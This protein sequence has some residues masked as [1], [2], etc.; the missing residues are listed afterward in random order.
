MEYWWNYDLE[1]IEILRQMS[2]PLPLCNEHPTRASMCLNP[3]FCKVYFKMAIFTVLFSYIY[4]CVCVCVCV[5][6]CACVC[7]CVCNYKFI[8]VSHFDSFSHFA[9]LLRES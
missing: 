1:N 3:G 5:C 2:V 7:V 8:Q 4:I 6:V 9:V